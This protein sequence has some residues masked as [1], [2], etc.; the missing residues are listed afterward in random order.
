MQKVQGCKLDRIEQTDEEAVLAIW[1]TAPA[2]ANKT[3]EKVVKLFGGGSAF[4]VELMHTANLE[5]KTYQLIPIRQLYSGL[6]KRIEAYFPKL[7][8]GGTN[9]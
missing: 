7:S 4:K 6:K 3:A 5:Q 2:S 9:D 8:D 1:R